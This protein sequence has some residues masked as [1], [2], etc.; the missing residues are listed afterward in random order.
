MSLNLFNNQSNLGGDSACRYLVGMVFIRL[1]GQN[2]AD[3]LACV[4]AFNCK[5]IVLKNKNMKI[6]E[7]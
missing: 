1:M 3:I 4:S 7:H 5:K 2:V 6:V